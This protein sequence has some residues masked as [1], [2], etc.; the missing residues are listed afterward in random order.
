[1]LAQQNHKILSAPP[2][3]RFSKWDPIV[4][5]TLFHWFT[6]DTGNVMGPWVPLEGRAAWTGEPAFWIRQIKQ[7]MMAGIDMVFVHLITRFE[8]QRIAFFA[9]HHQLRKRGYD[10]PKIVPFLDPFGIWPPQKVDVATEQGKD[11]VVAHYIRFYQQ[12]LSQGDDAGACDY[13]GQIDGR[14]VLSTWWVYTIL[15]NLES[16]TRED[17][18]VRLGNALGDRAA[19][20]KRGIHMVSTALIDPDLAFS[21]E[22]AVMFTG[23]LYV[24]QSI[25]Q[26]V[27]TFHVQAGYWDENLQ[28]P[29]AFHMP[30]DGGSHYKQAWEY[31]I[32]QA[33]FTHR[34]YVESWNEYDEGS[35]IYA[36][37]PDK[38]YVPAGLK[39]SRDDKW[40]DSD[41]AFEYIR[42][43]AR[44]AARFNRLPDYD[45]AVLSSDC[46]EQLRAGEHRSINF[47]VRNQGN[48][49]WRA[50]DG[51]A[52]CLQSPS[53]VSFGRCTFPLDDGE[54]EVEDYAG[55]FRGRPVHFQCAIKAPETPGLYELSWSMKQHERLFGQPYRT[56]LK[57]G[58]ED[59]TVVTSN[60]LVASKLDD[61]FNSE[62]GLYGRLEDLPLAWQMGH[63]RRVELLASLDI[64]DVSDKVCVDF[65]TGSWGF[66]GIYPRLHACR[67]AFGLDI[68]PSA[69]E[70]SRKLSKQQSFPY[71]DRIEYLQS[72]GLNL[73]L[74]DASAD[75]IFAGEA[76]EHVRYP[77]RFLRECHRVLREE[78]QLIITTPNR[79]AILYRTC[80]DQY[81][82]GPEHFWLFNYQELVDFV[83]EYF[84]IKESLGFN[85]S[86]YR[87]MDRALDAEACREWARQFLHTPEL[88][89]GLI[90]RGRRR[91]GPTLKSYEIHTIDPRQV[92][93]KGAYETLPLEFGMKGTMIAEPDAQISIVAPPCEGL[94]LHFWIHAWSGFVRISYNDVTVEHNLY[95]KDPG[96]KP[97]YFPLKSNSQTVLRINPTGRKD[98]RSEASQVI[99][100]EAVTFD[101]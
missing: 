4:Y 78:G 25:H 62:R 87:D 44:G 11:E 15:E 73:P 45:A 5:T 94:I 48:A 75:I 46:P 35:G 70:Q 86:I 98:P 68:S 93:I 52:F 83:S 7:I 99:F 85:G 16:F 24:T 38:F 61:R 65:G 3:R 42:I 59:S 100:F 54:N 34:V 23:L 71:G 97:V 88:A 84:D 60:Q 47:V 64:G 1:M 8:E 49:S 76:I 51:I 72:D 81:C 37:D 18:E 13:L 40:S 39:V 91:T 43:T 89:T 74:P 63:H 10:V 57:V 77:R 30:R 96:W 6:P 79:D 53:E 12:Y 36:A 66:A 50:A 14:I 2:A 92:T 31:V 56:N 95:A 67:F 26:G 17:V 82:V 22:R 69:L 20:F 19:V 21:D 101:G 80:S 28:R 9:A 29:N 32:G 58:L 27:R 90:M 41:D 33:E 55:V